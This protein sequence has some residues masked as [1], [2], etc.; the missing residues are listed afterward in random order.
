MIKKI[1]YTTITILSFSFFT[2]PSF[3]QETDVD[4]NVTTGG[5]ASCVFNK[6]AP[7]HTITAENNNFVVNL[8]SGG[9]NVSINSELETDKSKINVEILASI[10]SLSDPSALLNGETVSFESNSFDLNLSK[11]NKTTGKITNVTNDTLEEERPKASASITVKSFENNLAAGS[12]KLIFT[13]TEKT[14]QQL[15]EEISTSE[16]G[17]VIV[18]CD[19]S[20]IP[21]T[22]S[23]Q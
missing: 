23:F 18:R 22:T 16:N 11:E 6:K 1:L 17:S 13:N 12:I 8:L 3:A 19:F 7:F 10:N 4:V 2:Y 21:V 14:I 5:I 9:T 15:D 20:G